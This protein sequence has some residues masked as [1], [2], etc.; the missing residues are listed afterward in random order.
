MQEKLTTEKFV[1][2]RHVASCIVSVHRTVTIKASKQRVVRPVIGATRCVIGI[3]GERLLAP[4]SLGNA[5]AGGGTTPVAS[6][7]A[8]KVRVR[9]DQQ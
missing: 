4:F 9:V 1:F 5:E 7:T 2:T 3:D 6:F 8:C